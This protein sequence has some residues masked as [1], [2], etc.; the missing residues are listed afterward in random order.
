[1]REWL[2]MITKGCAINKG[3]AIVKFCDSFFPHVSIT[4][5]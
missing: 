4:A 3:L 2:L 5:V 1:M